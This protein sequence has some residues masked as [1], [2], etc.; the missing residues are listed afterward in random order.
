M[1]TKE[2][3]T[4]DALELL[5]NAKCYQTIILDEAK[6]VLKDFGWSETEISDVVESKRLPAR[7]STKR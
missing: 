4:R 3:A 1:P 5:L 7:W 6:G 2:E